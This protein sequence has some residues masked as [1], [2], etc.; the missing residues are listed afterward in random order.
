M[1]VQVPL[2]AVQNDSHEPGFC[3]SGRR[4]VGPMCGNIGFGFFAMITTRAVER[5]IADEPYRRIAAS[6]FRLAIGLGARGR[7][8]DGGPLGIAFEPASHGLL[9]LSPASRHRAGRAR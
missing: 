8:A 3:F 2:P 4:F 1:R 6:D 7:D 5:A 9:L